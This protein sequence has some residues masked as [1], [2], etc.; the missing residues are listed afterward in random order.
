MRLTHLLTL[1]AAFISLAALPALGVSE[2]KL[3]PKQVIRVGNG[4]EPRELD[5]AKATG[6]PESHIL[7]NMF[8]CLVLLDPVT[9]EPTPGTAE[10]WTV[11]PDGKEYTFIIRKNAK[12]SDG[13]PVTAQD[14]VYSWT[15]LLDPATA[16]EYAYQAYYIKNGEAFN[17]GKIK[18]PTQL[19]IKA[20]D[21]RTVVISL[22]NPTPFFLSLVAFKNLAP[23]PKHVI[24]KFKGAAEWTKEG[25]M[26]SNGPFKLAEW[27]LNKHVKLVPNEFYWDRAKVKLQEAYMLPI[28]NQDTEEK[29]FFAGELQETNEVPNLKVPL[30]KQ[31]ISKEPS[32]Y[33][34]FKTPAYLGTYFFRVNVTKAPMNDK[35]VRKALALTIDRELIVSKVTG[36]GE[37]PAVAYTPPN[38]AGYTPKPVLN[39][40]VKPENIAEAKKLLAE[41]G[42]PDGKG[43]PKIEIH[44]NTSENHKK[45]VT[46]LQQ[47]WKKNLGIEVGLLNEEWKVYL[48]TQN[49]M[50][51]QI[52]RSGW[53]GDYPDPNTFLD[54]FVTGGGNNKTGWGNAEYDAMIKK[55][56]TTLDQKERFAAFQRAEEIILDELPIIPVYV[57]THKKLISEKLKL[58]LDDGRVIPWQ[59]H[60]LGTLYL[61]NYALAE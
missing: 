11:S 4:A 45:I 58:V 29:A 6:V 25:N 5:P 39:T 23:V 7:E 60:I 1:S 8:E 50:G 22:E 48:N 10:S 15:R 28:E 13:K 20:K 38:T 49:T 2:A 33:H 43:L 41:A 59:A 16:A 19:G 35:R 24:E 30:Y 21:D 52:S 57:Y 40:T 47:M 61:K 17:T 32:K 46:A 27:R 51:Y 54:M 12:W 55:A 18:D 53:I 44:Y 31:Q 37:M 34:P 14:F 42:Y 9:M 56:G 26:V 36:A 3:A